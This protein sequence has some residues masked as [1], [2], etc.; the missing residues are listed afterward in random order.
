[1][2]NRRHR[3]LFAAHS[4]HRGGAEYCLQTT[5]E[6]LD[7]DRFEAVVVFPDEG[8]MV[9]AARDLGYEVF[10]SPM[11]YWL[12]FG[13]N[14]WYWKNL[15]LTHR[16]NVRQMVSL[17]RDKNIELVYTN[18][19]AVFESA[20]AARQA[21][22][23][24]IWHV[25]EVLKDGNRMH[26]LLPLK[27][28]KRF[29]YRNSDA[30]IFESHSSRQVF[31]ETTPGD[32]SHVV[33]NSLRLPAN[34]IPRCRKTD[35]AGLGLTLDDR[36]AGFVGSFIE[37]KNPLL[38]IDALA[39]VATRLPG[40]RCLLVGEGLLQGQIQNRIHE[41]DLGN[42]CRILPFQKDIAPVMN[43][44]DVLILP[45][46]QESFGLVTLEA[47]AFERPTIACKSQGPN[48]T[49][50]HGET[51]F[52][53][54]QNDAT[55]LARHIA[56]V[57][58]GRTQQRLGTEAARRVSSLFHPVNNTRSIEEIFIKT[59]SKE[60]GNTCKIQFVESLAHPLH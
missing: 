22:V 46:I 36:V 30:L 9:D 43:S 2:S 41:L 23:P 25:H 6:H 40:L 59:I 42:V 27:W 17:I 29:I 16:S 18:S 28:M 1:M 48:E 55:D 52:L 31:E 8:P 39:Q 3:V 26:Q 15:L 53:I 57:F 37:R 11:C 44:L 33:Y 12:N 51:G 19:T 47:A 10:I 34:S 5:L 35:R 14:A 20:V 56:L 24:H 32:R 21:K 49:I 50:I 58:Q 54:E 60:N 45:S 13:K 4:P 38:L 7:R